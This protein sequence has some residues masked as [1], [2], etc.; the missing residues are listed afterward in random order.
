M[1]WQPEDPS[2][3]VHWGLEGL[4]ATLRNDQVKLDEI[5]YSL[6]LIMGWM[7]PLWKGE[8]AAAWAA[9]LQALVVRLGTF[10]NASRQA[11]S[12][13][14]GYVDAF[15]SIRER[16]TAAKS[17]LEAALEGLS[18]HNRAVADFTGPVAEETQLYWSRKSRDLVDD[19]D[20]ALTT[21]ER[22]AAERTLA[23]SVFALQIR[24]AIPSS[25][26]STKA[27]AGRLG[28]TDPVL[29]TPNK[30]AAAAKANTLGVDDM[31]EQLQEMTA[32]EV[33]ALWPHLPRVFI[34]QL[35]AAH[36]DII[37]NLE[38]AAYADRSAANVSRLDDLVGSAQRAYERQVELAALGKPGADVVGALERLQA[39]RFLLEAYGGGRGLTYEPQQYVISLDTSVHGVP[40][41]AIS[42]GNLD[43]AT[44]A[45]FFIPG[46]A[47]SINSAKDYLRGVTELHSAD[48]TGA[49]V[50]WLGYRSPD[51]KEVLFDDRAAAGGKQLGAALAGFNAIRG[52]TGRSATLNVV[53]HS[54][55]TTTAAYALNGGDYGV[56]TFTMIG[57]AGIPASIS[58]NELNLSPEDVYATRANLDLIASFGQHGSNRMDP[59]AADWGANVFGSDGT[60][61][62]D[63][64]TQHNA[65]GGSEAENHH[66]YLS[67]GTE[68]LANIKLILQGRGDET[69]GDRRWLLLPNRPVMPW[70][71]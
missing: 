1:T 28:I 17:S 15:V 9:H 44:S 59:E 6:S 63:A 53:A 10:S 58:V 43:T 3:G 48:P 22:L 25:W 21:I 47:S 45:T 16:A 7:H 35:I 57:S 14:A 26:Q 46:M 68:S 54:Y 52:A 41:A 40:L 4:Q 49:T 38:G 60:D 37:G 69:T 24:A 13:V 11:E 27:L 2:T 36:P 55:G 8:G 70:E 65:V 5:A 66:K 29:M 23:E 18:K 71:D 33:A 50:L 19:R 30:L 61:T 64:V 32:A 67:D 42:V 51:A 20:Q 56:D 39:A 31:I 12:A 34:E 62:L